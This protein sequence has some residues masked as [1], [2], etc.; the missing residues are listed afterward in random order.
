M[1]AGRSPAMTA[2]SRVWI[3]EGCIYCQHCTSVAPDVFSIPDDTA[4]VIGDVRCDGL[5][6]RNA[7]ERSP[8]N[9]VGLEYEDAIHEAAEGCPMEIIHFDSA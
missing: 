7:N 5:T 2:I 6:S 9:A 8:L 4:V 1:L 3:D